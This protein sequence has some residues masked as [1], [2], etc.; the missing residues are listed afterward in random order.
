MNYLHS[1]LIII[2]I[3]VIFPLLISPATFA[4]SCYS[5]TGAESIAN[6]ISFNLAIAGCGIDRYYELLSN[7]VYD[8]SGGGSFCYHSIPE[9]NS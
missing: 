4:D 7:V 8:P 1:R 6:H 5:A 2:T 3:M 9:L